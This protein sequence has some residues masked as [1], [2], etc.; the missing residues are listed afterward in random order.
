M[1]IYISCV[2]KNVALPLGQCPEAMLSD[3]VKDLYGTR[4]FN[5]SSEKE[6]ANALIRAGAWD[7]LRAM[8]AEI[9]GYTEKQDAT[10]ASEVARLNRLGIPVSSGYI[11]LAV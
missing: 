9:D 2:G 8:E 1:I 10:A 6:T 7:T 3:I 4:N 11:R 5:L